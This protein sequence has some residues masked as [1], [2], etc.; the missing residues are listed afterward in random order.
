MQ[1]GLLGSAGVTKTATQSQEIIV[2]LPK[3]WLLQ[4]V[5]VWRS[6]LTWKV[7]LRIS[8]ITWKA[9]LWKIRLIRKIGLCKKPKEGKGATTSKKPAPRWCP[10]GITKTQKHR[11]QKMCQRELAEKKQEEERDYWFNRL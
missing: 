7:G 10:R 3:I 11:L 6:Q 8:Q 2:G 9:R 5:G 1:I 4:K